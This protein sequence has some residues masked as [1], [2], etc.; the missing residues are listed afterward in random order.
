MSKRN[1]HYLRDGRPKRPFFSPEEAAFAAQEMTAREGV[2][3]DW[4]QCP[5][6]C[7]FY[8]VGRAK[9]PK[10]PV[11]RV[12]VDEMAELGLRVV[13]CL[14]LENL[15]TPEIR[16]KALKQRFI[17]V[18]ESRKAFRGVMSRPRRVRKFV[19]GGR[20]P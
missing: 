14:R 15:G 16:E 11:I 7:S 12:N 18:E 6:E 13:G 2:K 17:A 3:L 8:H 10:P 19:W 1:P 5:T 4:Y 20:I 9:K